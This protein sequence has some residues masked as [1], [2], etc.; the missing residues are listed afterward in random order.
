[1]NNCI[2]RRIKKQHKFAIKKIKLDKICFQ[3]NN[4]TTQLTKKK[5]RENDKGMLS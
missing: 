5:G 3:I 2:I 4:L 1:M